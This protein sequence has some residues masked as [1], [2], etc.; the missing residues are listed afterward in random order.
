MLGPKVHSNIILQSIVHVHRDKSSGC[1][2]FENFDTFVQ[3]VE[4]Q[5]FNLIGVPPTLDPE[6]KP[7]FCVQFIENTLDP[8]TTQ[9]LGGP[10]LHTQICV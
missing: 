10:T 1:I 4:L 7:S 6:K 9:G 2:S 3:T 8:S 5:F